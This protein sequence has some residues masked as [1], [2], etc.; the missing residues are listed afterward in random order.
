VGIAAFTAIVR[1]AVAFPPLSVAVTVYL[2]AA[3]AAVG[4]PLIAPE[5]ALRLRPAGRAGLTPYEI[6]V[7]PLLD[8]SF[9][10]IGVSTM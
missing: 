8:G 10:V 6:T 2:I 3:L 9:S 4:I 5:V 1:T 7:P